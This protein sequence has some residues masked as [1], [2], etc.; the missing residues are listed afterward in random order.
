MDNKQDK[1]GMLCDTMF[2]MFKS[3]SLPYLD[4]EDFIVMWQALA[5]HWNI[6]IEDYEWEEFTEEV[7]SM[8]SNKYSVFEPIFDKYFNN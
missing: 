6:Y 5:E 2:R 7:N 4:M 3:G 1:L 8:A